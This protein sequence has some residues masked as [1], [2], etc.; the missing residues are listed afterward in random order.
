MGEYKC[1]ACG[2]M[3]FQNDYPEMWC[4]QCGHRETLVDYPISWDTHRALCVQY[5]KND[6]GPCEPPEHSVDELHERVATLE[7]SRQP[8]WDGRQWDQVQQ[9]RAQVNYLQNKIK[10]MTANEKIK[11]PPT[12]ITPL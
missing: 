1:P 3:A 6:P 8:Q 5:G 7:V 4:P 2:S 9:L 11:Q 10:E 12:G